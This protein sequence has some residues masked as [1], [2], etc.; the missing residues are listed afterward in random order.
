MAGQLKVDFEQLSHAEGELGTIARQ[1]SGTVGM[2]VHLAE[3]TGHVALGAALV[4]FAER[5]NVHREDMIDS[6]GVLQNGLAKVKT[7]LSGTDAK[8]AQAL[9][10]DGAQ[11]KPK[12][13]PLDPITRQG[14]EA[15]YDPKMLYN[16]DVLRVDP[17]VSKEL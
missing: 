4:Y 13:K 8:L 7:D 14:V 9:A 3:Q 5:W 15:N 1:L 16:P 2:S 10:G 12:P 17:Q 11:A 6:I